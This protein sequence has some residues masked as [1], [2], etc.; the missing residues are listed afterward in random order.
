MSK[1]T[2]AQLRSYDLN[3]GLSMQEVDRLTAQVGA[4]RAIRKE[5]GNLIAQDR[6]LI[7]AD[8]VLDM[9]DAAL[10]VKP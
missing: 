5:Y 3:L 9:V 1:E 6:G 10:E 8:T 7:G 2:E 4:I